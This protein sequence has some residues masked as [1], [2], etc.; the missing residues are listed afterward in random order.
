MTVAERLLTSC[1]GARF[2]DR[3]PH[4][5][6]VG[7]QTKAHRTKAHRKRNKKGEKPTIKCVRVCVRVRVCVC[8]CVCFK[9]VVFCFVLTMFI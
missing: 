9:I 7:V 4:Y 5:A 2:P 6:G 3:F 8:L 1:V